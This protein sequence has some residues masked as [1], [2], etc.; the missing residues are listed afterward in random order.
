MEQVNRLIT[1]RPFKSRYG[2]EIGDVVV[3]R[4]IETSQKKWKVDISARQDAALLLSAINLPG[5]IQAG[6]MHN[7]IIREGNR[8]LMNA[9]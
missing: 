7:L 2:G 3:G 6:Y 9:K 4:I 5:G 1:V 8:S